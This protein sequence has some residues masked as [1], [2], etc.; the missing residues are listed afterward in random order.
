MYKTLLLS[1]LA[2]TVYSC[3]KRHNNHHYYSVAPESTPAPQ[4]QVDEVAR[5]VD[6]VNQ[7]RIAQG[8]LPL[9]QGLT[10]KL[11]T[12]L[13]TNT[14]NFP[15]SLPSVTATFTFLGKFDVQDGSTS[16]GNPVL[17][18]ALKAVH[19]NYYALR[20]EGQLVIT[21][22]DY[23]QFTLRSDDSGLLYVGGSLVVNNN[24]LHSPVTVSGSKFLARGIHSIRLDY[25]Q[26]AGDQ[27]LQLNVPANQLYR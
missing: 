9:A 19:K 18:S 14:A 24:G 17:P 27:S 23:Y 12:G 4:A 21:K 25:Y 5:V 15:T 3:G 22:S 8:Q 16:A 26:A 11:Y 13:P 10:C 6:E 7:L 1:L 20:C 2:L